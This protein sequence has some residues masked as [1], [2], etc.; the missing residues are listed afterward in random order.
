LNVEYVWDI[1][2]EWHGFPTDTVNHLV[3][4][5]KV[6]LRNR[7]DATLFQLI[8]FQ[9]ENA[10]Q[11]LIFHRSVVKDHYSGMLFV[12]SRRRI[13]IG[14]KPNQGEAIIPQVL[15]MPIC[16]NWKGRNCRP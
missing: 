1:W 6:V 4:H 3:T 14:V 13:I 2:R 7:V 10:V 16:R 9:R 15:H 5:A 11:R 12:F 8:R